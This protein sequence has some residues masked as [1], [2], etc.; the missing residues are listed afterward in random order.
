[1]HLWLQLRRRGNLYGQ[2]RR[3]G[4]IP[5]AVMILRRDALRGQERHVSAEHGRDGLARQRQIK[6][7]PTDVDAAEPA[8]LDVGA[9]RTTNLRL[10]IS[11]AFFRGWHAHEMPRD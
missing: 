5:V 10:Q 2:V 7:C 8:R 1:A 3:P 9:E 4:D 11:V 6:S